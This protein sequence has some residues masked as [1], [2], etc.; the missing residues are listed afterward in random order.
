MI[1][2]GRESEQDRAVKYWR[3]SMNVRRRCFGEKASDIGEL[4]T[5]A[6][7]HF[8]LETLGKQAAICKL[9]TKALV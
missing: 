3:D 2:W 4:W 7:M 8:T 9:L 1:R 6:W 5:S